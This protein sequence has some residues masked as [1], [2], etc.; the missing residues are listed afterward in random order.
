MLLYCV[1]PSSNDHCLWR[2]FSPQVMVVPYGGIVFSLGDDCGLWW[3]YVFSS[4][5]D[6]G[7]WCY[8]VFSSSDDSS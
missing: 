3:Y 6:S 2:Y 1:F 5:D 7:L 4:S 8:C